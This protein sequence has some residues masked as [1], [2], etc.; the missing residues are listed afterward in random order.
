MHSW[1]YITQL[2][3]IT[4]LCPPRPVS[5]VVGDYIDRCIMQEV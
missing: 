3:D 1:H 5:V 4:P 2:D